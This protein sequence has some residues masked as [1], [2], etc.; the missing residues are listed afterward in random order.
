MNSQN[1]LD[2]PFKRVPLLKFY[3]SQYV[4]PIRC[5]KR[6]D[7]RNQM[8]KTS[9]LSIKEK[10]L[11]NWCSFTETYLGRYDYSYFIHVS[12]IHDDQEHARLVYVR[13]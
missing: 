6:S 11:N 3:T 10:I 4:K 1:I 7:G 8:K 13:A 12:R 9:C 5:S 2:S